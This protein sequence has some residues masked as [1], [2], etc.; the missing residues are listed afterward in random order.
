MFGYNIFD[1]DPLLNY[2]ILYYWGNCTYRKR[3]AG[4]RPIF[5]VFK[6]LGLV[7]FMFQVENHIA[8]GKGRL[9]KHNKKIMTKFLYS[10]FF[11]TIKI[12]QFFNDYVF[13]KNIHTKF[14]TKIYNS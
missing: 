9:Y 10:L 2:I 12:Y 11:I 3:C 5:Q 14:L 4:L 6:G 13:I 8:I 1:P 7:H